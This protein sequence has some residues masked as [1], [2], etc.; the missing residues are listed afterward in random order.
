MKYI[1][2]SSIIKDMLSEKQFLLQNFS[3]F[4]SSLL[5]II[6][7]VQFTEID[8]IHVL[9]HVLNIVCLLISKD[10]IRFLN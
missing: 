4:L 7:N 9:V 2:L 5:V 1:I 8:N 3:R 10:F 6:V